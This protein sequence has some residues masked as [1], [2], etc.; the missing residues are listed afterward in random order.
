MAEVL[1]LR[2]TMTF[3]YGEP[4]ELAPGVA[5]IV[6]NNPNHFT[7]KGTNTYLVGTRS[8]ALIDPGPEDPEHLAA[9]LEAVAPR[10]ITHV[11]ITHTHRD[12]TDGMPALLAATGAKTAGFA[13]APATA[14]PSA[15]APRAASS[16]T[17]ISSPD[18]PLADGQRLEGDGW[19]FTAVHT[20]GHA[21]DHLCFALEGTR[22]L[23]SGDHV[24]GW[25]TS[26]VAPPEGNMGAY[27]R[28]LQRLTERSDEV[29]FP[30]HG[31]QVAEPQRLVKAYLLHR[32]M[33]EQSIL[34]CIRNGTNTVRAIVPVVY[35]GLDAKLLNAASL[36]VLAH[37]EHLIERGLV[38]CGDSAFSRSCPFAFLT[39]A[40]VRVVRN[41]RR[42]MADGDVESMRLCSSAKKRRTRLAFWPRS[43]RPLREAERISM[44]ERFAATFHANDD[45]VGEAD[46]EGVVDGLERPGLGRPSGRRRF[47]G[48]HPPFQLA[49]GLLDQLEGL[50]RRA[51]DDE[52]VQIGVGL[53][54]R[55]SAGRDRRPVRHRFR[56]AWPAPRTAAD[57]RG[58]WSRR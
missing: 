47:G 1:P 52:G 42:P 6:A 23:F 57:W 33:R 24:M 54:R 12:H 51:V 4:R 16:W 38:H 48:C 50:L 29:Y 11:L 10:Q 15:P 19:A 45:V 14:A 20:P 5:R 58:P 18:I 28:S 13:A 27:V 44:R 17:R 21:P 56:A 36:S 25:N 8:L 39:M 7:F 49:H 53:R 9:I 40:P 32:R 41:P 34:E 30:G 46:H 26:V 35:K 55:R 43:W 31:G 3:A 2:T 22:I 37:V